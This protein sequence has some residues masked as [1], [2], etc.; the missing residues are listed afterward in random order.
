MYRSIPKNL[1]QVLVLVSLLIS[2]INM[3]PLNLTGP[4]EPS[5]PDPN[6]APSNEG[7]LVARPFKIM[8]DFTLLKQIE[9]FDGGSE[10]LAH[11]RNVL[12]PSCIRHIEATYQPYSRGNVIL[13]SKRCG[14]VS[15]IAQYY[16]VTLE[17]DIVI[18]VYH[19]VKKIGA[20]AFSRACQ[21]DPETGR[22]IAG[23]IGLNLYH[24]NDFRKSQFENNFMTI[25]HE[26][27][28]ILGFTN[29]FFDKFVAP[30]SGT[31]KPKNQVVKIDQNSRF[32]YQIVMREVLQYA[33]NHYGC[34]TLD[35]VPL[36][37][38]GSA[39]TAASHWDKFIAA[40]D[41]MGP[42]DYSN[43]V[44]SELTL[45]FMEGSGWYK[46]NPDMVERFYWA[47]GAG[48]GINSGTCSVNSMVCAN[49]GQK[50]CSVDYYAGGFCASDSYT[51]NCPVFKE[52][53]KGDCRYKANKNSASPISNTKSF[54]IGS[55]CILSK[56]GY[57]Q[58]SQVE[59]NA[60]CLKAR[61]SNDGSSVVI[62]IESQTIR[63]TQ[64]FKKIFYSK[65][66]KVRY[67]LCPDIGDFCRMESVQCKNQCSI[68]G[69]CLSNGKCWCF[70][71]FSGEDCSGRTSVLYRYLTLQR[72]I[73]GVIF[74]VYLLMI[75][76]L[77]SLN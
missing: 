41:M 43:P 61:C 36:E 76:L 28:H 45:R 55:K 29:Y 50:L 38:N 23:E 18:F 75:S 37:N 58:Y 34:R 4:G 62:E 51:E 3:Q 5:Q 33:R 64:S 40:S 12:L 42:T 19:V 31:N 77:F 52:S 70:W 60:N 7:Q 39:G 72:D 8:I 65:T 20:I 69:R 24:M 56:I 46:V 66:S 10:A 73:W 15:N 67:V 71:G 59:E 11:I 14:S 2:S 35:G 49:E 68:N 16:R 30:G 17:A 53:S 27:H 44:Y 57:N 48:C 47:K 13:K 1:I 74:T 63:C 6:E 9:E 21:F 32:Q 22:P 26:V 25:V 54:G